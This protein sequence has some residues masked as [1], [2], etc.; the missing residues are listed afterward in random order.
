[1]TLIYVNTLNWYY[2][3]NMINKTLLQSENIEYYND[4]IDRKFMAKANI[5]GITSIQHTVR[6]DIQRKYSEDLFKKHKIC[7]LK[8]FK[9]LHNF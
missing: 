6:I 8:K 2:F 1:M 4:K 9:K 7:I 5:H 3:E